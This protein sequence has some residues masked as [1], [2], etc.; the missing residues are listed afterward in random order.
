VLQG[1]RHLLR[2][3]HLQDQQSRQSPLGSPLRSLSSGGIKF[4]E[5]RTQSDL[6]MRLR[7]VKAKY[8]E[9][10]M[11]AKLR[12]HFWA[13]TGVVFFALGVCSSFETASSAAQSKTCVVPTYYKSAEMEQEV[14]VRT[15]CPGVANAGRT[16]PH[17]EVERIQ[18][19][20]SSGGS[21]GGARKL[22]CEFLAQGC[23]NLPEKR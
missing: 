15:N 4:A 10:S 23:G 18:Y 19:G 16:S 7:L 12:F 20:E 13:A 1:H 8:L 22:P 3:L 5:R 17:V 11:A 6:L 2:G 21:P 14:G 9:D